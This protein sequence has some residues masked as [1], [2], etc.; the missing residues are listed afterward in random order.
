MSWAIVD[1]SRKRFTL[2]SESSRS[3]RV[4]ESG[5]QRNID[6]ETLRRSLS[7][8]SSR[9][10]ACPRC[11]GYLSDCAGRFEIT[12]A[13]MSAPRRN[14]WV[15]INR[16]G[17]SQ[18]LRL[19]PPHDHLFSEIQQRIRRGHP[20]PIFQTRR[21]PKGLARSRCEFPPLAFA[22]VRRDNPIGRWIVPRR[23]VIEFRE[24]VRCVV[25]LRRH[26]ASGC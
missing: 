9:W 23:E 7:G 10:A 15:D 6:R 3:K 8:R 24:A 16:S 14:R 21:S 4:L 22:S 18:S 17:P 5:P 13:L 11:F 1:F 12:R 19:R 25:F 20:R 26:S 2:T